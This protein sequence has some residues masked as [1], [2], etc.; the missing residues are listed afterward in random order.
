M[1]KDKAYDPETETVEGMLD[2]V[3]FNRVTA[4]LNESSRVD[5]ADGEE[6]AGRDSVLSAR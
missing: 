2:R 6:P 3:G 5:I 4:P 1:V